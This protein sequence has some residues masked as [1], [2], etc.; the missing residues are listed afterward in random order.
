MARALGKVVT[1][2]DV[3]D[4]L[5]RILAPTL[6]LHRK[7]AKFIQ[8]GHGRYL[9][10]HIPG[11]RY[12]EL[13]GWIRCTGSA[14]PRQCSTRSR[15]SSPV[16]EAG[17]PSARAIRR[18]RNKHGRRRVRCDVHQPECCDCVRGRDRRRCETSS[19]VRGADSPTGVSM[20]SRA[21]PVDGSCALWCATKP[22]YGGSRAGGGAAPTAISTVGFLSTT[23]ASALPLGTPTN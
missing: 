1:E 14:T 7:D 11:S 3:R 12:V 10:A 13:P 5:V 4:T 17:P 6:I 15:N 18:S 9:S 8:V 22:R 20:N 2:A 21:C 23:G 19:P 16:C